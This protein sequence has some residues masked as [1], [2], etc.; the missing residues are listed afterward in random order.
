[1]ENSRKAVV[2]FFFT[3]RFRLNSGRSFWRLQKNHERSSNTKI[4]FEVL[5]TLIRLT[6]PAFK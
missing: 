2:Q 6:N 4:S 3:N 1:M 5:V